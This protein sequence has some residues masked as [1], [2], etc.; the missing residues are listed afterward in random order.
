MDEMWRGDAREQHDEHDERT[1]YD[2]YG[3]QSGRV[4]AFD[5]RFAE[6][7]VP[8][9][10]DPAEAEYQARLRGERLLPHYRMFWMPRPVARRRGGGRWWLL[11]ALLI[12]LG[13]LLLKP[14]AVL[15]AVLFAVL[16]G[17]LIFGLLAAGTLLLAARIV[18]GGRAPW[19]VL[20][21]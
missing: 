18:S 17:V 7:V 9:D 19:H 6:R 5:G 1:A 21:R 11:A 3:E 20:R 4:T 10:G 14:Q 15:A 16:L 13:L 8:A 2:E 12:V